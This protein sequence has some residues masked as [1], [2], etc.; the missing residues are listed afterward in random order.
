MPDHRVRPTIARRPGVRL[1]DFFRLAVLL[2]LLALT[3]WNLW[4]R[5]VRAEAA[6]A[7]GRKNYRL[8]L[9]KAL[10]DLAAHP[11]DP[12]S[13]LIAAKSF[14]AL[15]YGDAAEPFYAIAVA[16]APLSR[17]DL[18][19]RID[20]LVR[21]NRK[22][23]A[24]TVCREALAARPDDPVLLTKLA[25]V[26]WL[27]GRLKEAQKQAEQAARTP[28]GRIDGLTLLAT[29]HHDARNH[30]QA[31]KA[32]EAILAIDPELSSYRPGAALFW[33]EFADD[34][35]MLHRNAEARD[36]LQ[37]VITPYSDPALH[38]LLGSALKELG[39]L[40]GAEEAWRES[41]RRDPSRLNPWLQRGRLAIGRKRF[42]DA[43]TFLEKA[44]ALQPDQVEINYQLSVAH[45]LLGH[46]EQARRFAAKADAIRAVSPSASPASAGMG[47][48]P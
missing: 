10:D 29:I 4:Q 31:A 33:R 43:I 13:S 34:L 17:D 25:T 46:A 16:N 19:A 20:G 27:D 32:F 37:K 45:R 39:D 44:Y 12:S 30:E 24:A 23:E 42:D 15:D 47:A 48:S 5:P 38:D 14:S 2:V 28:E 7:L 26:E 41:A 11:G 6:Q 9:R 3:S 22:R 21:S 35:V 36:Y 18:L 1:S 8:A 40:A